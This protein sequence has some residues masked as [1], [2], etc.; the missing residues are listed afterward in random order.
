MRLTMLECVGFR[1]IN[2]FFPAEKL[3]T[4]WRTKGF[5]N[6]SSPGVSG[7][8]NW[9]FGATKKMREK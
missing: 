4:K 1:K 9:M 7:V 6:Q 3:D 5:G 8:M 2:N